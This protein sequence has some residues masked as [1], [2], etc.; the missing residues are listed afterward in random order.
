MD[1]ALWKLATC[2]FCPLPARIIENSGFLAVN[3]HLWEPV[4]ISI[5]KVEIML[6]GV[7]GEDRVVA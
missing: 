1:P 2:D 5:L 6:R 7:V 3:C 4:Q